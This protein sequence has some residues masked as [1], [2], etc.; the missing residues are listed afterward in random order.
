MFRR[1]VVG[2]WGLLLTVC[3]PSSSAPPSR[4]ERGPDPP[5]PVVVCGSSTMGTRLMPR[6]VERWLGQR[7]SFSKPHD[8]MPSLRQQPDGFRVTGYPPGCTHQRIQFRVTYSNSDDAVDLMGDGECHIGMYSGGPEAAVDGE[9]RGLTASVVG[10]DAIMIVASKNS[11]V[12][13]VS[14]GQLRDWYR[15]QHVPKGLK[16]YARSSDKSGTSIALAR[17]LG[18]PDGLATQYRVSPDGFVALTRSKDKWL[19]YVS[20]QEIL[21]R[22]GFRIVSVKKR[23]GRP[24][25][26]PSFRTVSLGQYP[27]VRSLYLLTPKGEANTPARAFVDW[28]RHSTRARPDF[29]VLQMMHQTSELADNVVTSGRCGEP[30]RD[31]LG[32]RMAA[33]YFPSEGAEVSALQTEQ[34]RRL[35]SEHAEPYHVRFVVVG[36]AS[37]RGRPGPNCAL[38]RQRA[39]RVVAAAR[40]LPELRGVEIEAVTGGPT[41][42]WGTEPRDNRA[43]MVVMVR[44]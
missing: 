22:T 5:Q 16:V 23:P 9:Y 34:L 36:Y 1:S 28:A 12:A 14:L 27:L 11:G 4:I 13:E 3:T 18:L 21:N 7:T 40:V 17:L 24:A 37:D 31:V 43:A 33:F 44:D 41:R 6:L 42:I 32:T 20:T 26:A 38:A 35:L 29:E 15:G 2:T 19:Y 25:Y 10:R 30:P 8:G 39:A